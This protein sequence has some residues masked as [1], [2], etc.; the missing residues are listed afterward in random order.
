MGAELFGFLR[1]VQT[2]RG[3]H[4]LVACSLPAAP[5]SAFLNGVGTD[6][7]SPHHEIHQPLPAFKMQIA[8][9]R[10]QM[11]KEPLPPPQGGA[12]QP[13]APVHPLQQRVQPKGQQVHCR[14]E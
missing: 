10:L 2:M 8:G 12:D 13:V 3:P 6:F 1:G 9:Q 11:L 7:Q 5:G 14:Q 4:V